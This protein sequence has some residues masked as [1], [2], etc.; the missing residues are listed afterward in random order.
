MSDAQSQPDVAA[1]ATKPGARRTLGSRPE[2]YLVYLLFYFVPWIFQTPSG[3]DVTVALVAVAIF[4]PIHFKSCE[5][6]GTNRVWFTLMIEAIAFAAAP[7]HGM[8]GVFHIYAS[9]QAG[10]QRPER[11]GLWILAAL[12]AAYLLLSLVLRANL[13]EA[14]FVI[15][16]GAITGISCMAGAEQTARRKS[17]ERSRVLDRQLA[18]IAERERIARDLHD[19]LGHALTMVALKA[20]VAH[21]LFSSDPKRARQ[22]ITEI[23]DASRSALKDVRAAVTGMNVTT[24]EAEIGH[25]QK[26]LGAAGVD[27]EVVGTPPLV[28]AHQSKT[29]GL[30]IREAVTNIVRHSVADKATLKFSGDADGLSVMIEDNGRG[31]SFTPGSGLTGL[32]QRIERIG[33]RTEIDMSSG[34]RITLHLPAA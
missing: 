19:L 10:Y 25:A 21:K 3:I 26:A 18:A 4:I 9:V 27:F 33:G 7:F 14:V 13:I 11:R 5:E 20:E 1:T 32:R 31:G 30:A 22:E 15:F 12:A 28:D 16:M 17:L 8:H 6:S 2:F 23:R 24:I 34:A 29:L